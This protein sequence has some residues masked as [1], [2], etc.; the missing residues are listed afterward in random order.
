M[1]W[2][3]LEG[4]TPTKSKKMEMTQDNFY[5]RLAMSDEIIQDQIIEISQLKSAVNKLRLQL[6]SAKNKEVFNDNI[7]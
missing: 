4:E 5:R 7:I 3:E 6:A 2:H 1:K